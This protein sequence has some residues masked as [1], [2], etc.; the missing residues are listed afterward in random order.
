MNSAKAPYKSWRH[1]HRFA[2]TD[3]GVIMTDILQYDIGKSFL[4][5][6]AG[7]FFVEKKVKE[8]FE[9]RYNALEL[10]FKK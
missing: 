5:W 2:E 3:G 8:I 9:Y 6:L 1:E 10:Y 7:K 4:G